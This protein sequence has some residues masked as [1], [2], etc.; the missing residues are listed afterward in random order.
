MA[1]PD[2]CLEQRNAVA[3]QLAIVSDTMADL[4]MQIMELDERIQTLENCEDEN[5][6]PFPMP[7]MQQGEIQRI[8]CRTTPAKRH[9]EPLLAAVK[10]DIRSATAKVEAM[11]AIV[12][13]EQR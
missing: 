9:I 13:E 2:P 10:V 4:G 7:S 1:S 11:R 6:P 12:G 5:Q 8:E 3:A